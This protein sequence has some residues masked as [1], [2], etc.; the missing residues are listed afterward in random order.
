MSRFI[1]KGLTK[2]MDL[3]ILTRLVVP[4]PNL[5]TG[6]ELSYVFKGNIMVIWNLENTS[7]KGP[8]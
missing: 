3:A 5:R 7:T 2:E 4:R 1:T 6:L 8:S